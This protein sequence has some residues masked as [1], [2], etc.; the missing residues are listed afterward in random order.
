MTYKQISSRILRIAILGLL[1]YSIYSKCGAWAILIVFAILLFVG[2]FYF[3]AMCIAA[4]LDS[5]FGE[6]D[7]AM[8]K[9]KE[10]KQL[11][12][13]HKLLPCK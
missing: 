11:P 5:K 6:F 1:G 9:Q 3:L 8:W 13:N 10:P 7:R 12:V 2:F 4:G